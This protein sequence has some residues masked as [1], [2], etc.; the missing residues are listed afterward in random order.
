[1]PR[2]VGDMVW[3]V[4]FDYGLRKCQWDFSETAEVW[5]S[6]LDIDADKCW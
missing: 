5:S 1:M 3:W 6:G 4:G 2:G